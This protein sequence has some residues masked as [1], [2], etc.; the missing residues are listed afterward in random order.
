MHILM[1]YSTFCANR[2]PLFFLK[3]EAPDV[4]PGPVKNFCGYYFLISRD[5]PVISSGCFIPIISMSVGAMS[6]RQP[7]SLKV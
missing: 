7:P 2:E 1:H 6:A 3:K 5:F 4:Y